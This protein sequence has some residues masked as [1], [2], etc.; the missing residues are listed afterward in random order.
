MT[1]PQHTRPANSTETGASSEA[2]ANQVTHLRSLRNA[3]IGSRTR[4]GQIVL[5]GKVPELVALLRSPFDSSEDAIEIRSIVATILGSLAHSASPPTLLALLRAEAPLSLTNCLG[6]VADSLRCVAPDEDALLLKLLETLLRSLRSV[7]VAIAAEIAPDPRC[8]LG[9]GRDREGKS[10]SVFRAKSSKEPDGWELA[11][12]GLP[13][14]PATGGCAA[15]VANLTGVGPATSAESFLDELTLLSR[16]CIAAI[17]SPTVLPLLMGPFFMAPMPR[18]GRIR[19]TLKEAM[20]AADFR[21]SVSS[22][23]AHS[24]A[25][26]EESGKGPASHAEGDNAAPASISPSTTSAAKTRILTCLEMICGIVSACVN[27]PGPGLA[28]RLGENC[29]KEVADVTMPMS[30]EE[31]LVER[32]CRISDFS[33]KDSPFRT[34]KESGL[35]PSSDSE[36]SRSPSAASQ[37]E[38]LTLLLRAVESGHSKLQE[39][40]LWVLTELT[41]DNR[42]ISARLLRCTTLSKLS[43]T[44]LLLELRKEPAPQIRLAAFSCMAN[45]VKAHPFTAKTNECV[46][47]VFVKLMEEPG[48]IRIAAV[49]GIAKIVADDP[50]LQERACSEEHM[51][52]QKLGSLLD[53]AT[54]ALSAMDPEEHKVRPG[55]ARRLIGDS[56]VE[57][58]AHRL[59]EAILTALAALTFTRDEVRRQLIDGSS[60]TLLPT[61]VA[62]LSSPAVGTRIAA[63][64]LIRALSRS[65]SILRTSL[66]DAGV[67]EK[68]LGI[69]KDEEEHHEVRTQATATICNLVLSFSPM[70]QYLLDHGGITKLVELCES[71]HGPTRLNALWAVKNMLYAS[72]TSFKATLMKDLGYDRLARLAL[73]QTREGPQGEATQEATETESRA[74]PQA[75]LGAAV[76]S[77]A[78]QEQALNIVRNL[79]SSRPEDIEQTLQGF[80]GPAAFFDLLETVIWQRGSDLVVEQAAYILV[81]VATGD[82]S[83]RHALLQRPNLMDAMCYFLSH[84]KAE[85][86]LAAVWAGLNLTQYT[87]RTPRI[88]S[89][90]TMGASSSRAVPT[91]DDSAKNAQASTSEHTVETSTEGTRMHGRE[92]AGNEDDEEMYIDIGQEAVSRLRSY[93]YHIRLRGLQYDSARDVSD[94]A[95]ALL[96]RFE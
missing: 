59:R 92:D 10:R 89:T 39:A 75:E 67:A 41:R 93:D 84:P 74:Q 77:D 24:G 12:I 20:D 61:A 48:N 83:H 45:I 40:A 15:G 66:V 85:I 88:G 94:R 80:G 19:E 71:S 34:L 27:I 47:A 62:C 68:L 81:N 51:C 96:R 79:A 7:C 46:L 4:K 70:R 69:I 8:G 21:S 3:V 17:F 82:T 43:P 87:P 5:Q 38:V 26:E 36:R 58:R 30:P 9:T 65:I 2:L 6:D 63:C 86:R 57:Q 55:T 35:A 44:S 13:A 91:T 28:R 29:D 72:P 37:E 90:T 78:L 42:Q 31:E 16:E 32:R 76:N 1:L 14:K 33:S 64:R 49:F 54:K 53:F 73:G 56:A 18:D 25:P 52:L 22:L 11:G 95:K 23:G 60:P 50:D